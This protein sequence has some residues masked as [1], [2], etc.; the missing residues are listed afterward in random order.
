MSKFDS[1]VTKGR[2][3]KEPRANIPFDYCMFHGHRWRWMLP[4]KPSG[5]HIPSWK[6]EYLFCNFIEPLGVVKSHF[7]KMYAFLHIMGSLASQIT[8]VSVVY[9][10]SYSVGDQRKHQN[11]LPLVFARG[12]HRWPVN[13]PKKGQ[14]LQKKF[15]F[16]EVIMQ[17]SILDCVCVLLF[18]YG[19]KNFEGSNM[20]V[21]HTV[22]SD[23]I[24]LIWDRRELPV[25]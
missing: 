11:S 16:A 6:L 9:L 19:F 25:F 1:Q 3:N 24:A 12:N 22:W 8:G 7:L 5:F 17:A 18:R 13:S 14:Q 21:L 10:T 2:L 4:L 23:F 20:Y 15:P